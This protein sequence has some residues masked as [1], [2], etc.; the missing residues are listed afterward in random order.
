M[1]EL[2][3]HNLE[4]YINTYGCKHFIET[5]TGIGTGL[6]YAKQFSFL[7]LFSI[8]YMKE[9]Y[10]GCLLRFKGDN[11]ITL[12]NTDSITGL[13]QILGELDST[14]ILFWLDAHFPGADFNYNSYHHYSDNKKL[15]MPLKDEIELITTIRDTSKD[16]FIID[17]LRIYEKGNYQLGSWEFYDLYGGGGV[18]FITSALPNHKV[19]RDYRHQGFLILTPR[20]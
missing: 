8:E 10:N 3:Q 1:G 17:D 9:L 20:V 16:V 13:E 15:H 4:E 12:L 14:P 5:G 19:T 6:Q 18:E 11:R 2:N 7:K